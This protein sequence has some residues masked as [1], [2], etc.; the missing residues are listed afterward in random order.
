VEAQD[1]NQSFIV[2]ARHVV[3]LPEDV[4]EELANRLNA[5]LA[6]DSVL[7]LRSRRKLYEP[8]KSNQQPPLEHINDY[9]FDPF[10]F[11]PVV[12]D[13]LECLE[14]ASPTLERP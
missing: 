13:R 9:G 2:D 7:G 11:P 4:Y 1:F 3:L 8:L 12:R 6:L 14:L 5:L 10:D